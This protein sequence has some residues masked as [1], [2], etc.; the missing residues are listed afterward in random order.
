M[1]AAIIWSIVV[2]MFALCER[3]SGRVPESHVAGTIA[4]TEFSLALFS[5]CENEVTK[6]LKLSSGDRISLNLKSAPAPLGVQR[7]MSAPYGVFHWIAPC[8]I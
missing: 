8:G 2:D 4:C 3:L 7:S 1:C 5:R 6:C